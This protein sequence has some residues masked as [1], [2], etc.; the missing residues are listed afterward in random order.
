MA[1]QSTWDSLRSHATPGWFRDAK[2]GIYTHWGLYSVP[3]CG[4]NATWYPYFMYCEGSPQH[5]YHVNTYGPVT[6]FGY[7]D[8]IPQFTAERFDPAEWADLFKRAGARFAGPVGE[9]HDGFA[10]WDSRWTTWNAARMGPCRDVVGEL[11]KAIRLQGMR[12]MVA[13][14]HAENWWFFPHWRKEFDT[15]DPRYAGLYGELHNQEWPSNM[16]VPP[17]RL[18][19]WALQDRPSQAFLE[20]WLGKTQEVIDKYQPDLLYFDYALKYIQEHYKRQALAYYYGMAETWGKEVIA[21]YKWHDE[22]HDLVP[23]SAV[24]DLELGR[25]RE[26]AYNDWLTDTTVDDGRG[27][28]YLKETKYKAASTLVHHLVDNVSKNGHLLLNVGPKPNGEI[29]EEAKELLLAIGS[30]LEVNGEAIYG[31]TPWMTYGEGPT[32]MERSGPFCEEQQIRYTAKDIRYTVKGDALYAICLGWP[33]DAIVLK[34]VLQRLY[35]S[36]I[37]SVR[38]LGVAE[39]LN[40]T[41]TPDGLVV[42]TPDRRPCEHAFAF[43]IA[44]K[45][46]F[47]S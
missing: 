1:Y 36:E 40:W 41:I 10:L 35:P 37:A 42:Q 15:S 39:E 21:T 2:F 30:W 17:S 14:H 18:D 32:Q 31:T 47:A 46:P 33:G 29:P 20:M 27:W 23:G 3:A 16:F 28:A 8:F 7:K 19:Q 11:G 6:K 24:V 38:M 5:D 13:L 9:H 22:W 12:Y 25:S 44:R 43:K 34:T 45:H 26:L 4:P